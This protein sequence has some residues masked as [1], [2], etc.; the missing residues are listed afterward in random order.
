[1]AMPYISDEN[2]LTLRQIKER[3]RL[4]TIAVAAIADVSPSLVYDMER[5]MALSA[6]D[7]YKILI[8][9]SR[10]TGEKYNRETVGGYW[11]EKDESTV[12]F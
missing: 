2:R 6:R 8:A 9:L 7:I 5:G 4:S 3:H 12:E 10:V 1:M 11:V